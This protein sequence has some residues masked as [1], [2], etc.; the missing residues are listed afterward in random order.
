MALVSGDDGAFG[1]YAA[2]RQSSVDLEFRGHW[3]VPIELVDDLAADRLHDRL[4]D[5]V[6]R[7]AAGAAH[8][9]GRGVDDRQRGAVVARIR[10]WLA[11]IEQSIAA[12]AAADV[13]ALDPAPKTPHADADLIALEAKIMAIAHEGEIS[14]RAYNRAEDAFFAWRRKNP[15]P[16][17]ANDFARWSVKR[18]AKIVACRYD[19]TAAKWHAHCAQIDQLTG[20]IAGTPA[21]TVEGINL[22]AT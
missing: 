22:G 3:A 13:G 8:P 2:A 14:G 11:T 7:K 15:Q 17:N 18:D 5:Q 9:A 12:I 19:E 4:D 20:E 6:D 1:L 21:M 10:G 16:E